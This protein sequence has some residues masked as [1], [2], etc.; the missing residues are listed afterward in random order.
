MSKRIDKDRYAAMLAAVLPQPVL[1][2]AEHSR[3][4]KWIDVLMGQ[5]R[6]SAEEEAILE[7]LATCVQAYEEKKYG[8]PTSP[9]HEIL[10]H[11]MEANGLTQRDLWPLFGTASR[12]SEALSG[13]RPISKTQAI[14]LARRFKVSTDLFLGV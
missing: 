3:Q 8:I 6:L 10:K 14:K 5:K 4:L 1:T 13:K 2:K 12:I 7:L 9:P 11:L